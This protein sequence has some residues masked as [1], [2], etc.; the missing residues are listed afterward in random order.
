MMLN[1][2]FEFLLADLQKSLIRALILSVIEQMN[3]D[4]KHV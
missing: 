2:Y 4:L 3:R 1:Y